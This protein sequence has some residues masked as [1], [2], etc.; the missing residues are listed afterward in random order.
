MR[1]GDGR[2]ATKPEILVTLSSILLR[3]DPV[4]INL[5][6]G[7]GGTRR[8]DRL[9]SCL[10]R[11]WEECRAGGTQSLEN[12]GVGAAG[13]HPDRPAL[14][15]SG[16]DTAPLSSGKPALHE[17][18]G[19]H[20]PGHSPGSSMVPEAGLEPAQATPTA[21]SRQRVYQ[22]HHPGT[23]EHTWSRTR[24]WHPTRPMSSTRQW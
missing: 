20:R 19:P 11:N 15:P 3:P 24:P 4:H 14:P 2:P 8:A 9:T 1:L 18:T 12:E 23:K 6:A 22:F 5:A 16:G 13:P 21:P 17:K 10:P 7:R